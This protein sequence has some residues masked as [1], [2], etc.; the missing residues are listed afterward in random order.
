MITSS[1]IVLIS[2]EEAAPA[3]LAHFRTYAARC[4]SPAHTT[5]NCPQKKQQQQGAAQHMAT[6]AASRGHVRPA[7]TTQMQTAGRAVA[8]PS[9]Q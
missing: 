5:A 3:P 6:T 4:G 8:I 7:N 2:T 9:R 1:R